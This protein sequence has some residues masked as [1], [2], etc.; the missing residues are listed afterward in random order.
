VK[1]RDNYGNVTE[2]AQ[3]VK[4]KTS[5]ALFTISSATFNDPADFSKG[6]VKTFWS[7]F[8]GKADTASSMNGALKLVSTDTKWDGGEVKGPFL[9]KNVKGDFIVQVEVTD[10][11]GLKAKKANGANDAGL[12]VLADSSFNLLQNSIFPGW[13]VGNMV[14]SLDRHGRAQTNNSSAWD[15]YK[16]LQIQRLG[17]MFYLR[18]SADGLHWKDLPGS[19]VSRPDLGATVQVGLFHATYGSQSGYGVF[20]NFT[21]IQQK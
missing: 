10:V 16:H 21:L 13:G 9:F 11:S 19:P 20:D 4:V 5:P 3:A 15:F 14:T 1:A 8:L 6:T 17:D 2:A 7:G 18:G 12:M